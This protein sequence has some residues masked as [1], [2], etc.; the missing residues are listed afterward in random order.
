MMWRIVQLQVW[1][2]SAK[3]VS[4]LAYANFDQNCPLS[5][6]QSHSVEGCLPKTLQGL[7]FLEKRGQGNAYVMF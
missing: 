7:F 4:V 1:P 3:R 5:I 2:Q 6:L